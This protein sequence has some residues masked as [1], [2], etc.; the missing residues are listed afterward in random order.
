M[1]SESGI[2][3]TDST[4]SPVT[5]CT[6]VSAGCKNCYAEREVDIRWSKNPKSIFY[7]RAF[8]DVR[9]HEEMLKQP[10]YWKKP[11]KIFVC[12]RGDLFHPDVPDN[13]ITDVF[14]VMAAA[15]K[16]T[17]Q[18]L[19]KRP[20]R[21]RDFMLHLMAKPMPDSVRD[22]ALDR[23]RWFEDAD[24]MD[25][26]IQQQIEDG[27]PNVWLGVSIEDQATADER[28]PL[29]LQTPAT[30]RW[31]SAEP[32]LGSVDV[33]RWINP[34]GVTCPDVCPDTHYVADG[35]VETFVSNG[36]TIPLCPYCGITASWTGYD[37]GIDWIVAGG[38]SGA[39]AR[40]MHPEWTRSLRDQCVAAGVPF[41]FKQHGEFLGGL[42]VANEQ[43]DASKSGGWVSL[44]GAYHNG[45]D[46]S[47]F[48]EGDAHVYRCGTKAA[49]RLIDGQEWNQYPYLTCV[50]A[51][52]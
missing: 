19:T 33:S 4:W 30:V 44:D 17:F 26:Y 6:K 20:E 13:F 9:C 5:G 48:R 25:D 7:G 21:M 36:E 34:T 39:K 32:L 2:I 52:A 40:P 42:E 51:K 45:N 49:G 24:A 46:R 38:E 14:M 12:P 1:S 29:L 8:A 35:D 10:L 31:I 43:I 15:S 41:L 16:H 28:I 11:R 22:A 23:A 3:W 18:V 47:A 37:A 50:E 27:F